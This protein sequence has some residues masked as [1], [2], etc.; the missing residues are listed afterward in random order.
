[1]SAKT[2][3]VIPSAGKIITFYSFKGG[4]GRTM[5]LANVAFLA[6][7]SGKRVLVM[8]WDLEAP[9]LAYYFRTMLD[10]PIARKLR[11]AP[12]M[13]DIVCEWNDAQKLAGDD[14]ESYKVYV[15]KVQD[16]SQ[17]ASYVCDLPLTGDPNDTGLLHYV[18]AGGTKIATSG[19][20]AYEQVLAEFSWANFFDSTRGGILLE[21]LRSWA[22]ATYDYI[23][24]DSRTGLADV[25]GICT[26]QMPDE[27]ALCFVLNRQNI[28]GVAK[29]AR[30]IRAR[31]GDAITLYPVPMRVTRDGT[32]E[33]S[34]AFARA[35]RDLSR[36]TGATAEVM[37][38]AFR[39]LEVAALEG[40]PFYES[41]APFVASKPE[42]DKATLN[43]LQLGSA[44]L[45][46]PLRLPALALTWIESTR[47]RQQPKGATLEYIEKL[48]IAE[49]TR[50]N[51]ELRALIESAQQMLDDDEPPAHDYVMA[52]IELTMKLRDDESDDDFESESEPLKLAAL[53][54]AR[55]YFARRHEN[56]DAK[57]LMATTL[58][59]YIDDV[60]FFP[61]DE[62]ALPLYEELDAILSEM[63]NAE[64][65]TQRIK[66][67]TAKTQIYLTLDDAQFTNR[68]VSE[69]RSLVA[70]A[71]NDASFTPTQR[72]NVVA[73]EVQSF[74]FS[75]QIFARRKK[76]KQANE[77]FSDGLDKLQ[78][79]RDVL[80][81]D[82][83]GNLQFE[84]C[85]AL[86]T[87]DAQPAE[88]AANYAVQA[89]S[90]PV[91]RYDAVFRLEKLA[92]VV[93]KVAAQGDYLRRFCANAFRSEARFQFF[94]AGSQSNSRFLERLHA[95]AAH[96]RPQEIDG[97]Q[98]LLE[99]ILAR[100]GL[101]VR[102]LMRRRSP[103]SEKN[104]SS[105]SAGV[106][107]LLTLAEQWQIEGAGELFRAFL[108][109]PLP[110]TAAVKRATKS[111]KT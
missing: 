60:A 62:E 84:L 9:G 47:R 76:F 13:L 49:P 88:I 35:S 30:A 109:A 3:T 19:S 2:K 97:D 10:A 78:L 1:M 68:G 31:R 81:D 87:L 37:L 38:E 43:Y 110:R 95:L 61:F 105:L 32:A 22:K 12:G 71:L 56:A 40:V 75:G 96:L 107:N 106:R 89:Y 21:A 103:M 25:A 90:T 93:L 104:A 86:A 85:V 82:D 92:E 91:T 63:P 100:A 27:V 34:D 16:G 108:S 77:A 73:A 70:G 51:T 29:V 33:Q 83:F 53:D 74:L 67:L 11:D 23:L 54:L 8:D 44:L 46:A 99:Q 41:L 50:R 4:V 69:I 7:M 66:S 20:P 79:R 64:A 26:M 55:T 72:A 15:A 65:K 59:R 111:P 6:A 24:I 58:Q 98:M 101:V 80:P 39:Q 102:Q 14:I 45:G 52:L 17:F 36:A 5:A 48:A 57:Q 18:G 42:F 94:D 28:E